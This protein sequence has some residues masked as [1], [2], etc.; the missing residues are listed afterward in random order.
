MMRIMIYLFLLSVVI[1]GCNAQQQEKSTYDY[2]VL[3]NYDLVNDHGITNFK[4]AL[5]PPNS[6]LQAA[7]YSKLS[8]VNNESIEAL[9][10]SYL[11][12]RSMEWYRYNRDYQESKD[13]LRKYEEIYE[14]WKT[15]KVTFELLSKYSYEHDGQLYAIAIVSFN[16]MNGTLFKLSKIITLEMIYTQDRW[17]FTKSYPKSIRRLAIGTLGTDPTPVY[18][19]LNKQPT[20]DGERL[21]LKQSLNGDGDLDFGKLSE[22]LYNIRK[23]AKENPAIE[24]LIMKR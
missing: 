9:A 23:Q 17:Y 11:S 15:K 4:Y 18:N 8:E 14:E 13:S 22:A 5:Y 16:G 24:S 20:N 19:I 6:I 1:T 3:K 7:E 12:E 10:T 2:G 21:L